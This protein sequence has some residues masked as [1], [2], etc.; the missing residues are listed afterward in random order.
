MGRELRGGK[1]KV[2]NGKEGKR[3]SFSRS[4][5]SSH[6]FRMTLVARKRREWERKGE[7]I[8]LQIIIYLLKFI[9]KLLT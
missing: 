1:G 5:D 7:N 2:G 4:G 9:K 6:S 8:I 3:R